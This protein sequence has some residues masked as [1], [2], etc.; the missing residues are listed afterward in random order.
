VI[1]VPGVCWHAIEGG[2]SVSNRWLWLDVFAVCCAACL[3]DDECL[4][5][6]QVP[7]G[8]QSVQRS[9][10]CSTAALWT[11]VARPTFG[12]HHGPARRCVAPLSRCSGDWLLVYFWALMTPDLARIC[13]INSCSTLYDFT[14]YSRMRDSDGEMRSQGMSSDEV[15][16]RVVQI[17][18]RDAARRVVQPYDAGARFR[19]HM[20]NTRSTLLRRAGRRLIIYTVSPTLQWHCDSIWSSPSQ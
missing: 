3:L 16:L 9:K 19:C 17:G 4:K 5:I 20:Q 1:V 12:R 18:K 14:Q 10:K 6:S 8:L 2:G 7:R 15:R 13:R 11:R